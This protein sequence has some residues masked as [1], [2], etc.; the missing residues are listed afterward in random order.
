MAQRDPT[1][2][3][4]DSGEIPTYLSA[5]GWKKEGNKDMGGNDLR[6]ESQKLESWLLKTDA[7][8][9]IIAGMQMSPAKAAEVAAYDEA[10][11]KMHAI[12]ED[13]EKIIGIVE[14]DI[15]NVQDRIGI[16]NQIM[17]GIMS[18]ADCS[19]CEQLEDILKT[20][21]LYEA[22]RRMK[23]GEAVKKRIQISNENHTRK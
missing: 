9:R 13:A 3:I 6:A 22:R 17:N 21:D 18:G 10:I 5:I 20:C 16:L 12:S 14:K 2:K 4:Q 11:T 7:V 8:S 23:L 15:E 19:G 1:E